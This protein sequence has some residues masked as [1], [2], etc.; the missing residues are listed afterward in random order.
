MAESKYIENKLSLSRYR[1]EHRAGSR[2]AEPDPAAGTTEGTVPI[3]KEELHKF[4]PFLKKKCGLEFRGRVLEL[5]AGTAWFSAELSKLPRVVEVVA[6]DFSPKLLREQAPKMFK[7][8]KAHEAKITRMPA[9]FY[10]LDFQNDH[11]DFVV[12]S[13]LLHHGVNVLQLLRESRRVL[14]P[15]GQFVAIREPVSRSTRQKRRARSQT[16]VGRPEARMPLYVLAEYKHFFERAGL[17]I[18]IKRMR[19]TI[20]FRY[21]LKQIV[22][23]RAPAQYTFIGTK[24][25]RKA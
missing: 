15:G 20:G 16:L 2:Q 8:L 11:F 7:L 25:S 4:V 10:Q 1:P 3:Q 21:Y 22:K 17:E 19:L 12:C 5:G 13:A 6:T 23:G 14:K 18:A 24:R 9:D